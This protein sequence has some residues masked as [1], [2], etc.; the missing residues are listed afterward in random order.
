[1]KKT[2]G[3]LA[4]LIAELEAD[5][6]AL[7]DLQEANTRA[8][9]RLDAGAAEDLDYAALG[10]TLH[11]IYNLAENAFFRIAKHFENNMSAETW[12]KD[13]IQRMTLTIEGI[14]PAVLDQHSADLL[15]DLRS[16]RH[17]FRNMYRKK[18]DSKKLLALEADLPETLEGFRKSLT[19]FIDLLKAAGR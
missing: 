11:N 4:L 2:E 13:L 15:D 14:R 3:S 10:Y 1:M 7:S 19:G 12:H 6:S 5:L 8:K 9:N 17:V 18:L 16:F